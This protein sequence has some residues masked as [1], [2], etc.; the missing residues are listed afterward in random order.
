M[1]SGA[2]PGPAPAAGVQCTQAQLLHVN[3]AGGEALPM[4]LSLQ[5]STLQP[6]FAVDLPVYV[7][8]EV[9]PAAGEAAGPEDTCCAGSSD[10]L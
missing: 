10:S 4:V 3:C 5:P 8:Q 1:P 7:L 6:L 2:L 9:P